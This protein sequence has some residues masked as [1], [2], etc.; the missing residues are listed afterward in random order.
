MTTLTQHRTKI[1][2]WAEHVT[3]GDTPITGAGTPYYEFGKRTKGSGNFPS[4]NYNIY[5]YYAGSRDPK[6]NISTIEP[7]AGVAFQ[8]TNGLE[9]YYAFGDSASAGVS[10][11]ADHTIG[12]I[13]QGELPSRVIRYQSENATE[14]IREEAIN[15]KTKAL[16]F[17]LFN[18]A[19]NIQ[20]P[21][22]IGVGFQATDIRPASYNA[23]FS[24]VF[25]SGKEEMYF[26]DKSNFVLNWDQGAIIDIV[27]YKDTLMNF[28]YICD[29]TTQFQPLVEQM[30]PN[31]ILDGVRTHVLIFDLLRGDDTRIYDDHQAQTR[32]NTPRDA[33][34]KCY[35]K[36][37][38][39][40][41]I[42]LDFKDVYT[43]KVDMNDGDVGRD[44]LDI[45]KVVAV[46]SS[47]IPTIRD[48]VAD[49]FYSD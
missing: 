24:P 8:P 2:G 3:P 26:A 44:E 30:I 11:D 41:Y 22:T 7:L 13:N 43:S 31:A 47:V 21:V 34:I 48:G 6:H 20:S 4:K 42:Q 29:M 1:I 9:F 49:G 28:Q 10:P 14:N 5:S 37:S 35:A 32:T 45:Y 15:T 17:Q 46:C 36:G 39:T 23:N 19:R 12:G 25:A 38:T 16:N 18:V 33:R 40:E 27:D